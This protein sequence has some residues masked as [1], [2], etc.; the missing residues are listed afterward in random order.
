MTMRAS[1]MLSGSATRRRRA[2]SL[3][4]A[5]AVSLAALPANAADRPVAYPDVV[6]Q[7]LGAGVQCLVDA[8]PQRA[9]QFID[10]YPG[11]KDAARRAGYFDRSE[12]VV[13]ATRAQ[14]IEFSPALYRGALYK[15][16]YAQDFGDAPARVVEGSPNFGND[17]TGEDAA[18]ARDYVV[19]RQFAECVVRKDTP[20]ARQ[21]VLAPAESPA[22]RAALRALQPI[23]GPCM[24][25]GG[26]A[27]LS[28]AMLTGLIAEALYRVS[29]RSA[30]TA[31]LSRG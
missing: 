28:K 31:S 22:E 26:S 20:T 23:L 11:S 9:R 15:V 25:Q 13:S 3:G 19:M 8:D 5:L 24:I 6:R 4:L 14:T 12:C 7:A 18:K 27:A 16:F 29:D 17:V 30:A 2:A 21:L 1:R 10:S